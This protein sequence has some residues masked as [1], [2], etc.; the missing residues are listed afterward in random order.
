MCFVVATVLPAFT[1]SRMITISVTP[2]ITTPAILRSNSIHAAR[3]SSVLLFPSDSF[4]PTSVSTKKATRALS[5]RRSFSDTAVEF[6]PIVPHESVLIGDAAV[7]ILCMLAVFVWA[8]QVVPVARTNLV[9]SK[10]KGQVRAYLDELQESTGS[11]SSASSASLDD[12]NGNIIRSHSDESA[13]E[14]P[15]AD[16]LLDSAPKRTKTNSSRRFERWLFADWL[17][18]SSTKKEAA[19]PILK[20]AKWNSG[21]NPVLAATALILVG[22]TLTAIVEHI[23]AAIM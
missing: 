13:Q 12:D 14:V 15:F 18:Y 20:K 8:N 6:A 4:G 22:V 2:C 1:F 17:Q 19:L 23:S 3:I 9:I 10:K 7:V 21:D 16:L 11:L 5:T